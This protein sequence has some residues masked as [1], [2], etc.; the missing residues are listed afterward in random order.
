MINYGKLVNIKIQNS[1]YSK[2]V[3]PESMERSIVFAL[4]ERMFA[5][6]LMFIH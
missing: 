1:S 6:I 5:R 2:D 4:A 3:L